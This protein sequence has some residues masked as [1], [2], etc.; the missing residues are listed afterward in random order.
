AALLPTACAGT[1]RQW[2]D[3]REEYHRAIQ[4]LARSPFRDVIQAY[5]D[6]AIAPIGPL[7]YRL[8][9][10]V[11]RPDGI[12]SGRSPLSREML[13][14][15]AELENVGIKATTLSSVADIRPGYEAW[16]AV[17]E[18]ILGDWCHAIIVPPDKVRDAISIFQRGRYNEP[19]LRTNK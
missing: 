5:S 6:Y 14:R 9:D 1:G 17:T 7:Q 8:R 16:R 4:Q 2:M 19:L 13:A 12:G 3:G 18:S 11:Q 15:I 10:L